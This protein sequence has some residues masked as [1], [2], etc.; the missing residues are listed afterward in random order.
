MLALEKALD[1]SRAFSNSAFQIALDQKARGAL[2]IFTPSISHQD[3]FKNSV[4]RER[5]SQFKGWLYAAIHAIAMEAAMQPVVIARLKG[6]EESGEKRSLTRTKKQNE[7]R[8]KMPQAMRTKAALLE[9]EILLD[10]HLNDC[11]EQPNPLQTR[12]EFTYNFVANINITGWGF[13]IGGENEEGKLEL[14]SVPTT[15]IQVEHK[16]KPFA[17]FLFGD[18]NDPSQKKIHLG[19]E[20]VRFAR[21]PN[22]GH[23]LGAYAPSTSQGPAVRIDEHIQRCQEQYFKNGIFPTVAITIGKDPHPDSPTHGVRPRLTNAQRRQVIGS[24]KKA[25][26]G[27]ENYGEPAILDG[28]IENIERLSATANEMGWDSS[29]DKIRSRIMSAFGVHPFILGEPTSLGSHAQA[30]RIEKRFCK[31]VNAFLDMLS[32]TVQKYVDASP[33]SEKIMCWWEQCESV[34]PQIHSMDLRFARTQG[35]ISKNEYRAE[36]GFPPDENDTGPRSK[37]LDNPNGMMAVV[38][39]LNLIAQGQ[40]SV[41]SG[42]DLLTLF[43][44]IPKEEAQQ[45]VQ[46]AEGMNLITPPNQLPTDQEA[47]KPGPKPEPGVDINL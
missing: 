25:M 42:A 10:H 36:L 8:R 18:P 7:L 6:A 30:T 22:P 4:A 1:R 13:I 46:H 40:I 44:Q 41:D 43:L 37:I 34:D 38:T 16:P 39:M 12:W 35:D 29:E 24:I 15:W 9:F 33:D 21:F 17:R 14:Y 23:P 31:R 20:V 26:A 27:V 32:C 28:L 5:M 19:P 11:L 47:R 2:D 3:Q 45:I